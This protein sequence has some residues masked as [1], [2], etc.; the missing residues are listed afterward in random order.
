MKRSFAPLPSKH[1]GSPLQLDFWN[2]DQ[3]K[4]ADIAIIVKQPCFDYIIQGS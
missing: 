1:E 3:R 4:H 2:R